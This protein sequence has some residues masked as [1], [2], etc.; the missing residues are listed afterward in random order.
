MIYALLAAHRD[1]RAASLACLRELVRYFDGDLTDYVRKQPGP[2]RGDRQRHPP[3]RGGRGAVSHRRSEDVCTAGYRMCNYAWTW[4]QPDGPQSVEEI[5]RLFARNIL[6]GLAHRP[7]EDAALD[8]LITKAMNTVQRA[9]LAGWRAGRVPGIW[10][11][12][13]RPRGRLAQHVP[14]PGVTVLGQRAHRD[15]GDIPLI[16]LRP[17]WPRRTATARRRRTVRPHQRVGGEPG[18]AQ[19]RLLGAGF[20]DGPTPAAPT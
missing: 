17:A 6:G 3:R 11:T 8:E 13:T 12:L 18:R 19:E 1:D 14:G 2:L 20:L 15:G 16:D 5:A 9:P 4:Y 7:A 10:S